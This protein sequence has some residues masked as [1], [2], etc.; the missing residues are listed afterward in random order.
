MRMYGLLEYSHNYSMTS[1][2]LWNYYRDEI[3]EVGDSALDGKSYEYKTKI[4]GKTPEKPF[5][6]PLINCEV[7][8]DLSWTKDCALM[9]HHNNITNVYFNI[10]SPKL[11][12]PKVTLSI[13]DNI[14]FLEHVKQGF[15]RTV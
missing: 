2:R 7:E 1:R 13:T 9:E 15:Q 8:F 12:V 4:V 3:D 14:K 5:D 11:Y 10:T 6:L